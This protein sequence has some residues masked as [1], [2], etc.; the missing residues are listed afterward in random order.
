MA[1][2]KTSLTLMA[3]AA[4]LIGIVLQSVLR[5]EPCIKGWML[6]I[7]GAISFAHECVQTGR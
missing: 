1:R 6:I 3:I 5:D 4:L 2:L 7:P